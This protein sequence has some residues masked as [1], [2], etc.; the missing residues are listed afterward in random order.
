M[1][2]KEEV[3][4]K[5]IVVVQ[6][7]PEVFLDDILGLPPNRVIEFS[8]DL[9]LGTGPISMASYRMSPSE[10]TELKK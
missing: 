9:I 3:N 10:L 6:N 1:E 8:I 7:F 5:N 2:S 4:L